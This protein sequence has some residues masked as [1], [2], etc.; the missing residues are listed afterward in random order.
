MRGGLVYCVAH[1]ASR[2]EALLAALSPLVE[3][4]LA[5]WGSGGVG[6]RLWCQRADM[7]YWSDGAGACS[8]LHGG[9]G[10][11]GGVSLGRN[12]PPL[13]PARDDSAYAGSALLLHQVRN[14]L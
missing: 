5:I 2:S 12:G 13:E 1:L 9:T 4:L 8:G 14:L 10:A 3:E 7:C 6:V 11:N